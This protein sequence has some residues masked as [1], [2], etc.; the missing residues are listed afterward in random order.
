[1]ATPSEAPADV[2]PISTGALSSEWPQWAL[3]F[4]LTLAISFGTFGD[5]LDKHWTTG[6]LLLGAAT[7]GLAFFRCIRLIYPQF[8]AIGLGILGIQAWRGGHCQWEVLAQLGWIWTWVWTVPNSD[9][10]NWWRGAKALPLFALT[11][12]S[13]M[14]MHAMGVM[15]KGDWGHGASYEMSMPWAHRN[16]AVE[17]LFLMSVIGGHF[18]KKRWLWWWGFITVLALVYQVRSVLLGSG[19]WML[20]ALWVSN[21]GTKWIK[22]GFLIAWGLFASI[23]VYILL[24]SNKKMGFSNI[25]SWE[26][27]TEQEPRIKRRIERE[28][29]R[30]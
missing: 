23:Q 6:W 24:F 9:K 14:L 29:W 13:V 1:M 21:L 28:G 5:A 19:V 17:S 30:E 25:L 3:F 4:L 10:F 15:M 8:W 11:I 27:E 26:R 16:I 2:L 18:S 22:R 7:L 20:Y 12:G